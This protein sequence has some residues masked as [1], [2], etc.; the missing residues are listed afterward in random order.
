MDVAINRMA[1]HILKRTMNDS[2]QE[3]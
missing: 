1:F 3:I 2:E